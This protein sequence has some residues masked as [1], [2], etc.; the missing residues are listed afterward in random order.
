MIGLSS[1]R[2]DEYIEIIPEKYHLNSLRVRCFGSI[3]RRFTLTF[4][5]DEIM[6]CFLLNK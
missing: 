4:V 5:N 2:M 3:V 6:A 1:I